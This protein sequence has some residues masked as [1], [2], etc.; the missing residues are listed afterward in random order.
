MYYLY[1]KTKEIDMQIQKAV[2]MPNSLQK[3][4]ASPGR[5]SLYPF[6]DMEV[7]DSVL[8]DGYNASTTGCP[9]YNAARSYGKNNGKRFSGKKEG[10][11]KVR[12]WR[13]E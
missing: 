8:V 4:G 9:I 3:K 1:I 6:A 12:V 7:G 13:V 11:G 5:P 10:E 2:P